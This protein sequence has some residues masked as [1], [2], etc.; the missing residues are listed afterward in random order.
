MVHTDPSHGAEQSDREGAGESGQPQR[1]HMGLLAFS[2]KQTDDRAHPAAAE[3][4]WRRS[5]DK[6]A[7]TGQ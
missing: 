3:S 7:W 2:T 4:G 6:S 1:G 5:Y